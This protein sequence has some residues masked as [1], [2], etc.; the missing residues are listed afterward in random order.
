MKRFVLLTDRAEADLKALD[1]PTRI[2]IAAAIQRLT[3]GAPGDIKKLQ[4]VDPPEYRLRVGDFRIRFSYLDP[5][6]IRI[7]RIQN[8]KDAYR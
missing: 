3:V 5:H 2:R 8:R 4:G 6:T 1:R 7:N